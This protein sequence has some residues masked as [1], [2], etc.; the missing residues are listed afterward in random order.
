MHICGTLLGR[1]QTF[2]VALAIPGASAVTGKR[3]F[4]F[5]IFDKVTKLFFYSA[6]QQSS[7][8][9]L[10]IMVFSP[11]S[12]WHEDIMVLHKMC[13]PTGNDSSWKPDI[14]QDAVYLTFGMK[15]MHPVRRSHAEHTGGSF[16]WTLPFKYPS[17]LHLSL[18]AEVAVR[19][20]LEM[21]DLFA[22]WWASF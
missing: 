20:G 8:T 18:S 17:T 1:I 21:K 10:P 3:F 15:K 19:R 13:H 11:N 2:L 4:L 14:S 5:V 6:S 16:W 9:L 12:D 7:S 22:V